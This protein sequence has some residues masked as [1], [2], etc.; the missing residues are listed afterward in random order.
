M[1]HQT[2]KCFQCYSYAKSYL[3]V[4]PSVKAMIPLKAFYCATNFDWHLG[5]IEWQGHR[6]PVINLAQTAPPDSAIPHT[7]MLIIQC[8]AQNEPVYVG[9]IIAQM[10]RPIE[11]G[12]HDLHFKGTPERYLVP[13]GGDYVVGE[14]VDVPALSEFLREHQVIT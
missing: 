13:V 6:V 12:E 8:L 11:I 7:H 1:T 10:A 5:E 3:L 9:I 14:I 2:I 4:A